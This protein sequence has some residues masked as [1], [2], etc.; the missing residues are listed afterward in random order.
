[1]DKIVA[2][3]GAPPAKVEAAQPSTPMNESEDGDEPIS[4]DPCRRLLSPARF[5]SFTVDR[6]ACKEPRPHKRLSTR[7]SVQAPLAP[8]APTGE[9]HAGGD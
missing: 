3:K 2:I 1:M 5:L 8:S 9:D 6:E 7:W 4:D